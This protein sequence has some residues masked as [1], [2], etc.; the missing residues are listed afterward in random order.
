MKM[1]WISCNTCGADDYL[2]ATPANEWPVGKCAQCGQVYVNPIPV[3]EV[4]SRRH[5]IHNS[6]TAARCRPEEFSPDVLRLDEIQLKQ[7]LVEIRRLTDQGWPEVR[8]LDVGCGTGVSIKAAAQLGWQATGLDT[9]SR[10]IEAGKR[11]F[12][13]DLRC[14]TLLDARLPSNHFHF[15]RI[16]AV[17]GHL[18]NPYE[19]LLETK[20][21]LVQGGM[22]LLTTPNEAFFPNQIRSWLCGLPASV[23]NVQ[24]SYCLH[25]YS[26][27]TIS[28][29]LKRT[30]LNPVEVK[31]T[32]PID[33]GYATAS[34]QFAHRKLVSELLSKGARLVGQ[35]SMLVVWATK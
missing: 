27:E 14:T 5:E 7:H 6:S 19:V 15:I 4:I 34:N 23:V 25:S 13:V 10:L 21:I 16:R 17:I 32:A 29:L 11:E 18:Y 3:N 35:G 12:G 28:K 26:Q 2:A 33:P 22:L 1:D 31:M 9:D 30:G 24:Q 20:R 8:F